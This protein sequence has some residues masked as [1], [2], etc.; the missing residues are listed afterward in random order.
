MDCRVGNRVQVLAY[1]R[2]CDEKKEGKGREMEGRN[3]L[4]GGVFNRMEDCK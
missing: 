4:L 2:V 3:E 1:F